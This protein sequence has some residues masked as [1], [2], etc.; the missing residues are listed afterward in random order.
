MA[1]FITL[2]VVLLA[3]VPF[4]AVNFS[5]AME[6]YRGL[7]GL[8]GLLLPEILVRAMRHWG[9]WHRLYRCCPIWGTLEP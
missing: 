4:R 5:A 3:W 7:F 6:F 9:V 8:N 1:W 2:F